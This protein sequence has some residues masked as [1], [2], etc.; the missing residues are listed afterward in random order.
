MPLTV[1][2]FWEQECDVYAQEQTAAQSDM[3]AAQAALSAAKNA[4]TADTASFAN[5]SA[6]I[7]AARAQLAT[8]AVPADVSALNTHIRDLIVEQRG[9][10]GAVLDDQDAAAWAQANLGAAAATLARAGARLANA[11]TH[12][13][14]AQAEAQQRASIATQLSTAPLDA[15]QTDAGALLASATKTNA[16]GAV[17]ASIPAELVAI[18]SLRVTR[19]SQVVDDRRES[20]MLAEN[21]LGGEWAA[22]GGLDG[23]AAK[24]GVAFRQADRTVREY[25]SSAKPRLD[26]ARAVL[27]ALE[28][29]ALHPGLTAPLVSDAQKTELT[30]AGAL[31]ARQTAESHAVGIDTDRQTVANAQKTLD[32]DILTAIQTDV[33]TLSTDATVAAADTALGTAN[34]TLETDQATFAAGDKATLDDW[35]AIIGDGTWQTVLD[36]LTAVADITELKDVKILPAGDADSLLQQ[37]HEAE[38]AYGDALAAAAKARRRADYLTDQIA[39]RQ[40]RL[41][42]ATTAY[43]ARA[44]SAVRGDS[45]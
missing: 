23:A 13:V 6:Q 31:A 37:L 26:K 27:T 30:D 45:F 19:R 15:L 24:A 40:E 9:L 35:Q 22:D 39:L 17:T 41:D 20:V 43:S 42:A 33:D 16:D 34:T 8:T 5:V 32:A 4:L 29:I 12:L 3:A 21:A 7:Q 1:V 28:S 2:Q 25:A 38:T 36:Y 18:A 10:Q 11:E 14:A 44:L